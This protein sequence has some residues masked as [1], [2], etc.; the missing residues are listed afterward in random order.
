M[1]S[2][3]ASV[4]TRPLYHFEWPRSSGEISDDLKR[5]KKETRCIHKKENPGNNREDY[6]TNPRGSHFQ[7]H[8]GQKSAWEQP[9]QIY[10]WQIVPNQLDC[11]LNE[12]LSWWMRGQ[13]C[14]PFNL[15]LAMLLTMSHI[16][17]LQTNWKY[18]D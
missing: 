7:A 14:M 1:G 4:I 12:T 18:R 11:L 13:L 9:A 6:T 15:T 2:A 8:K 17:S 3:E 10:K 16:V 5:K